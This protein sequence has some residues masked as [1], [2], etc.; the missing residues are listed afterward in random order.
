MGRDSGV[1]IKLCIA[2]L[3]AMIAGTASSA[4]AQQEASASEESAIAE[5]NEMTPPQ[6]LPG[7]ETGPRKAGEESSTDTTPAEH[8]PAPVLPEERNWFGGKP[9]W[10]WDAATGDWGGVR[11]TLEDHGLF[12]AGSYTFDWSSVWSGGV[13]NVASTR[14]LF[15][16]NLTLDF[17]RA[18]ELHGGTL[19]FDYYSTD[20]RGGSD[21]VGDFQAFDN[22]QTGRNLDQIAELWYEQRF[23]ENDRLRVKFGKIEANSEFAFLDSAAG[24]I[25]SS[26]AFS[27]TMA[28]FPTYPDPATGVVVFGY[29]TDWW[30]IGG[31]FFDGATVD[32]YPTGYRGIEHFHSDDESDSWFWIG[33]TGFT[34]DE[35]ASLG[36]GRVSAGFT[37]HTAEF[38]T[39]A[40]E[41][42][43]GA[44]SFYAGIEQQLTRR[45]DDEELAE[46]GL[47]VFARV[48]CADED[49]SEASFH[50]GAGVS[51]L[52]T[53]STR[54]DDEAGVYYSYVDLSDADGAGFDDDEQSIELYYMFQA[55]QWLTIK[56]DLQFIFSPGGDSTNDNAVVG[57]LR[58]EVTF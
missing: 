24:F 23:F 40:G 45:G 48:G 8:E 7:H 41:T 39:F 27:P 2:G 20:G 21:D 3:L 10:E 35:V 36:R 50:A 17:E 28:G 29:P 58:F 13:K 55:T 56:P 18:F 32:G 26:A 33:E 38:E 4:Y 11:T 54:D 19:F 22:I 15:D 25:N 46:K 1:Q 16:L 37:Y 5:L 53:F 12:V 31:G 9:W 34:W 6:D 44:G 47:Y 30:Y 57:M 14:S 43:D 52:G 51:I 42:E 49:V